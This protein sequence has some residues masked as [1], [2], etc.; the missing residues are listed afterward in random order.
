MGTLYLFPSVKLPK[1]F[2]D[3]CEKNGTNSDVE[4][5]LLML[6]KSGVCVVP[7]IGFGQRENTYYFRIAFFPPLEAIKKTM[8]LIQKF[9]KEFMDKY[10]DN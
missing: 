8:N 10:R 7:G 9:H 2:I 4:Y 5:C 1:K 6:E 3:E